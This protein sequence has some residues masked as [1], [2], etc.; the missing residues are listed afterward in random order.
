MCFVIPIEHAKLRPAY[1]SRV[2]GISGLRAKLDRDR[3]AARWAAHQWAGFPVDLDPR[4][5]VLTGPAAMPEGGFSTARAKLAFLQGLAVAG[6]GVPAE[7]VQLLQQ[8]VAAGQA[9]RPVPPLLV[10]RAE[11]A[12]TAFHTDRGPRVLPAWRVD[13][14]DTLGPIWVLD[15]VSAARCWAP[16]PPPP[17]PPLP[18]THHSARGRLEDGGT[19]L[20]FNFVG[21]DPE[22]CNY[23][24]EVVEEAGALT[25]VPIEQ[26]TRRL[27]PGTAVHTL[28]YGRDLVVRLDSPLGRRVLVDFDASP[29]AVVAEDQDC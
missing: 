18:G 8:H 9:G 21:G 3:A 24:G 19:R 15:A 2:P 7:P 23:T 14:E 11:R 25:V 22:L 29:I 4:P 16:Q 13:A 27:Q 1:H 28:G 12:E 26:P 17:P 5:I 6:A 10:T 20:R